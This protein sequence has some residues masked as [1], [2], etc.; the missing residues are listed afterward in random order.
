MD[1]IRQVLPLPT[2]RS[3]KGGKVN[4]DPVFL[5]LS[6][7]QCQTHVSGRRRQIFGQIRR[8]RLL[9]RSAV[10]KHHRMLEVLLLRPDSVLQ[11]ARVPQQHGPSDQSQFAHS[12]RRLPRKH[13]ADRARRDHRRQ[14]QTRKRNPRQAKQDFRRRRHDKLPRPHKAV[15]THADRAVLDGRPAEQVSEAESDHRP[16]SQ[17]LLPVHQG[18]VRE[19]VYRREVTRSL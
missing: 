13:G 12:A 11:R 3:Q 9:L 1:G 8:R 17:V 10:L 2:R 19:P 15:R 4:N 18:A 6:D 5:P 16:V 14:Q 7:H